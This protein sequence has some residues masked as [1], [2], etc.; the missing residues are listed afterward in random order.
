MPYFVYKIF[1]MPIHRLEKLEQ[2]ESF[3]EASNRAKQLRA[4]FTGDAQY[5]IKVIFAET[6]LH[7][8]DLLSQVRV[9]SPGPGDD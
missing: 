1:K 8:D 5:V 4:G 3:R 2:H 7:A 6:E 9:A